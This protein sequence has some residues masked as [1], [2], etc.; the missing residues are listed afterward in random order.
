MHFPRI[1][2]LD[3]S[4]TRVYEKLAVPGEW[5]VPG[6]FIF[7]NADLESLSGKSLL[8]FRHGFL[9]TGSFG[10]STLVMVDS[11]SDAEYQSVVDSMV[12]RFL[13]QSGSSDRAAALAAVQ[14]EMEFAASICQHE[15]HTL[16]SIERTI[17]GDTFVENFRVVSPP[18]AID[19][20]TMK[21]WAIEEDPN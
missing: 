15:L 19:H 18:N 11:I 8:A 6:S 4:D 10:W 5:A 13:K 20:S 12:V 14:E 9:G 16:L 7:L 21:L 2:R 3:E 1:V 17:E